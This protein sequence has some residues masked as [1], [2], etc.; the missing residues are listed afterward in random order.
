MKRQE[1]GDLAMRAL[2]HI[3]AHGGDARVVGAVLVY[4]IRV[5]DQAHV[6]IEKSDDLSPYHASGML[7]AA[8]EAV[9]A[10]EDRL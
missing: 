3:D 7:L 6:G 8:A 2:D 9:T 5:G 1:V 10:P 4:E